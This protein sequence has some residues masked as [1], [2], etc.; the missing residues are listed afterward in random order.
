MDISIAGSAVSAAIKFRL[1]ELSSFL[2]ASSEL[3]RRALLFVMRKTH[4]CVPWIALGFRMMGDDAK[5][6]V[7]RI[8]RHIP[9]YPHL[10]PAVGEI[11]VADRLNDPYSNRY[12]YVLWRDGKRVII[13]PDECVEITP[14]EA[15]PQMS[16]SGR[17][18]R[19]HR[20]RSR[21]SA[22]RSYY[23]RKGK[24]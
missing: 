14:E 16:T 17:W 11:V 19:M 23:R 2:T 3:T 4:F 18:A 5:R 6:V 8:K 21:E 15:W 22:L 1:S 12:F 13:R 20:E 10:A 24:K 9:I 7:I